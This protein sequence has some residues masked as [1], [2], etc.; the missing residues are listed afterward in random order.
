ML[1]LKVLRHRFCRPAAAVCAAYGRSSSQRAGSMGKRKPQVDSDDEV[2]LEPEE[3]EVCE[4]P[5]W[6]FCLFVS[7]DQQGPLYRQ[8]PSGAI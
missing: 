4:L 1:S 5:Q 7:V 6:L 8:A 2:S 3:V